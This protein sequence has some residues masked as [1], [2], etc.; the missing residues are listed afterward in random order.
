[1]TEY[2]SDLTVKNA[3]SGSTT[4]MTLGLSATGDI[5][6]ITGQSKLVSQM[7]F[8]L[9]NDQTFTRQVLNSPR[10]DR[11]IQSLVTQI[12]RN[13][14]QTQIDDTNRSEPDFSGYSV[15]RKAAGTG[16]KFVRVSDNIVTWKFVDTGLVN[17]KAY[18][19]GITRVY[20]KVFESSFVEQ[21]EVTPSAMQS[22]QEIV[23]GNNVAIIP[24]SRQATFYVDGPKTYKASELMDEIIKIEVTQDATEP[25]KWNVR[26]VVKNLR[27]DTVSLASDTFD[28][29]I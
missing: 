18:L 23:I 7:I 27:G 25:R 22:M 28:L 6:L 5:T 13:F 3:T 20:R 15:F 10:A 14:K 21:L 11:L 19:Y 29:R 24:E 8:S 4:K 16:D 9:V 17:D 1:M 2:F 12:Y 26:L